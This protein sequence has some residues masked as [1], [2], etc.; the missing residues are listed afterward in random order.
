MFGQKLHEFGG[1]HNRHTVNYANIRPGQIESSIRLCTF[2]FVKDIKAV[3]GKVNPLVND[4]DSF[5]NLHLLKV[6]QNFIAARRVPGT[7]VHE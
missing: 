3:S 5:R 6:F 2:C 4:I 7:Y 1:F